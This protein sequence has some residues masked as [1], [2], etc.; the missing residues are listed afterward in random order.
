VA[1]HDLFRKAV[2]K[3]E[4]RF[5]ELSLIISPFREDFNQII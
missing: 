4:R 5:G 1:L 2:G 3:E